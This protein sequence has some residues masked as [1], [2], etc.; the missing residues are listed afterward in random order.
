M[1][2]EDSFTNTLVWEKITKE[3]MCV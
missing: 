3:A 1:M 2:E